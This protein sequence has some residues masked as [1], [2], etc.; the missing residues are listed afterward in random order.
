MM[1]TTGK[2]PAAALR[3]LAVLNVLSASARLAAAA[4]LNFSGRDGLRS[5]WQNDAAALRLLAVLNALSASARFAAATAPNKPG[6]GPQGVEYET[7]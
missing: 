5:S 7:V 1:V 6:R 4:A 2:I 3:L